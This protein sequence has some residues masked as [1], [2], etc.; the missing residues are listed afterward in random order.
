MKILYDSVYDQNKGGGATHIKSLIR[1]MS[2]K[3]KCKLVTAYKHGNQS[4]P[5][6]FDNFEIFRVPKTPFLLDSF[7]VYKSKKFNPFIEFI[8]DFQV[9][10]EKRNFIQAE[11]F[12]LF[13]SHGVEFYR[14]FFLLSKYFHHTLYEKLLE[15]ALHNKKAV[16]TLHNFLPSSNDKLTRLLYD[17]HI[18]KFNNVI[19]VDNHIYNYCM[20]YHGEKNIRLI[21][22]GVD[23]DTF[24]LK[25]FSNTS[26][27]KIGIAGRFQETIDKINILKLLKEIPD[28]VEL[29]LALVGDLAELREICD[30]SNKIE[31]F[32]NLE[33]EKMAKFY[34]SI[35]ILFNPVLH[36]GKTLVTLESMSTGT[37]VVMY[38]HNYKSPI[39]D[40]KTGFLINKDIKSL[41]RL[42]ESMVSNKRKIK[43]MG[44]VCR[45]VI[46]NMYSLEKMNSETEIFY[47]EIIT[48][49]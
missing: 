47:K 6:T 38:G 32:E 18:K 44:I 11:E 20:R 49:S 8:R 16:L 34:S 9:L 13:H 40:G 12:D 39:V 17:Y 22:N 30:R 21:P 33:H 41:Y 43:E 27:L 28:N 25:K 10:K 7:R 36:N 48:L 19:C 24:R 2:S 5:K 35:D 3:Y 45:K 14:S 1:Y 46:K 29:Y 31:L 4:V 23:T 15:Y 37:P 42:I 26:T